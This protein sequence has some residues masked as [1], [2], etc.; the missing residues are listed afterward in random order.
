MIHR[1]HL[2]L[3]LVLGASCTPAA[4]APRPVAP[5][6]PRKPSEPI[7]IRESSAPTRPAPAALVTIAR[8]IDLYEAPHGSPLVAH[9]DHGE[10]LERRPDGLLRIWTR[11]RT[12]QGYPARVESGGGRGV[13]LF[14]QRD[15]PIM[16]GG[17]T[18]GTAFRGTF[19]PLLRIDGD[20]AEVEIGPGDLHGWV[21]KAAVGPTAVAPAPRAPRTARRIENHELRIKLVNGEITSACDIPVSVLEESETRA[22]VAYERA[23]IELLGS[24]VQRGEACTPRVALRRT[25]QADPAVPP[26]FTAPAPFQSKALTRARDVWMLEAADTGVGLVCTRWSYQPRPP[27]DGAI[28]VT[29]TTAMPFG[30]PTVQETASYLVKGASLPITAPTVLEL[31]PAGLVRRDRQGRVVPSKGGEGI[32]LCGNRH[33]TVVGETAEGLVTLPGISGDR[34]SLLG[35]H[36]DDVDVWYTD[37]AGCQRAIE[38]QLP[39]GGKRVPVTVSAAKSGC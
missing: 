19:L 11:E 5:A 35:Y 24:V 17:S 29:R 39:Q 38:R 1:L 12:V 37:Q 15:T 8:G 10:V 33:A 23:G 3:F 4:P 22:Q 32:G 28:S 34:G 7:V 26:G 25:G 16:T 30:G 31:E 9:V 2:P 6:A 18:I 13:G 21:A 20:M 27:R 36:P 14:A